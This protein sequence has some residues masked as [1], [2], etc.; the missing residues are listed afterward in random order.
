VRKKWI[1]LV[2]LSALALVGCAQS[3]PSTPRA[4]LQTNG[5]VTFIPGFDSLDAIARAYGPDAPLLP[6]IVGRVEQADSD[7]GLRNAYGVVPLYAGSQ[8]TVLNHATLAA[9]V[10]SSE[11]TLF[12][13]MD[14]AHIQLSDGSEAWVSATFVTDS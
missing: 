2:V 5:I 3:A 13:D 10:G 6:S 12:V 8:V 4:T 7:T 11:S 9:H 14:V 1:A